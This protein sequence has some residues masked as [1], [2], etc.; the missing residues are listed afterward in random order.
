MKTYQLIATPTMAV[1]G[2]ICAANNGQCYIKDNELHVVGGTYHFVYKFKGKPAG[3]YL[4]NTETADDHYLG[5][6]ACPSVNL[7]GENILNQEYWDALTYIPP[8]EDE[9]KPVE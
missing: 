1:Q 3:W 6:G 2:M 7:D 4:K 9:E 5:A 8:T